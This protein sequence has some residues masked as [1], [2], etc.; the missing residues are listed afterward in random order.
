MKY[1]PTYGDR[2]LTKELENSGYKIRST[3]LFLFHPEKLTSNRDVIPTN[4]KYPLSSLQLPRTST[5]FKEINSTKTK[6]GKQKT[7]HMLSVGTAP[8]TYSILALLY[9]Y[10]YL[11][12]Q[13]YL[14]ERRMQNAE[15]QM[16][17]QF[18]DQV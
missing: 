17:L 9:F 5:L 7:I 12:Y 11:R 15:R 2:P 10:F 18:S 6:R 13:G 4:K 16:T 3:V 14:A 1:L 8:E